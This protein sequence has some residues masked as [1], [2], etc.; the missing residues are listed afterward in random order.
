MN[1]NP[2]ILPPTPVAWKAWEDAVVADQ[3]RQSFERYIG[4]P[5]RLSYRPVR[6]IDH[7]LPG[8]PILSGCEDA[9]AETYLQESG[10][11]PSAME[12]MYEDLGRFEA[13]WEAFW[14]AACRCW[15]PVA[16]LAL[17]GIACSVLLAR[18]QGVS[19]K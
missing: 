16:W 6:A 1:T 10:Y 15:K 8:K 9:E 7:T 13:E 2:L 18:V 12:E 4:A 11:G 14:Q 3:C 19:G 5:P 17:G